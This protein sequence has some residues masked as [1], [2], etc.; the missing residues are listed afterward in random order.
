MA[1][2]LHVGKGGTRQMRPNESEGAKCD[3]KYLLDR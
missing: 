2:G 1:R 3:N